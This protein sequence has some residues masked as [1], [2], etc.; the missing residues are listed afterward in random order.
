MKK[1]GS[2]AAIS[3]SDGARQLGKVVADDIQYGQSIPSTV[4]PAEAGTQSTICQ[5]LGRFL[6]PGIRRG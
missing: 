2:K 6:G 5:L 4:M 3:A 1:I